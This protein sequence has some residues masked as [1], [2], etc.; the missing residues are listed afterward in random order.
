MNATMRDSICFTLGVTLLGACT[1]SPESFAKREDGDADRLPIVE[2]PP[3][4]GNVLSKATEVGDPIAQGQADVAGLTPEQIDVM[5]TA[6]LRS[7]NCS[8]STS[9]LSCIVRDCRLR[10]EYL[11]M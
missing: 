2:L 7:P 6:A 3:A 8:D 5:F 4:P 11:R 10:G 9:D 1:P